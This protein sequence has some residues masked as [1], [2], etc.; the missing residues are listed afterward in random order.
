[1]RQLEID[2]DLIGWTQ[3]FLTDRR[4]EIII[5]GHKN[6]ERDVE[7]GIPQGSPASPI[8]FLIY[9]SGVFGAVT[10]TSPEVTSVSFMDDLGFLASGNSIEEVATSLETTRE[11]VL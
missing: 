7:T 8:L 2:N 6:P 10:A 11:T 9:I 4:V 5:D 1:M 3:S